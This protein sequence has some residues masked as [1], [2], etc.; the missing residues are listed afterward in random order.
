MTTRCGIPSARSTVRHAGSEVED[1]EAFTGGLA[2]AG[3]DER[4]SVLS[5]ALDIRP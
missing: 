2:V 1:A 3:L 4:V 5:R